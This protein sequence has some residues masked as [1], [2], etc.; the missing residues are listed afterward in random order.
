VCTV[1]VVCVCS[2]CVYVCSVGGVAISHNSSCDCALQMEYCCMD[3]VVTMNDVFTN[4]LYSIEN[5]ETGLPR[6]FESQSH[7]VHVQ[8]KVI[9]I[10]SDCLCTVTIRSCEN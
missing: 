7:L 9:A 10:H 2:V 4:K 3:S 6:F 1:C 5:E 8:L